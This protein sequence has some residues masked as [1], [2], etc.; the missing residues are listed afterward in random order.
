MVERSNIKDI[1]E[2]T[3]LQKGVLFHYVEDPTRHAYFEQMTLSLDGDVHPQ[4]LEQALQ[5]LIEK[6]DVLRTVFDH[7]SFKQPVQI[8]LKH[9]TTCIHVEDLTGF[10][11]EEQASAVDAYRV[12]DRSKGFTLSA[13]VL[14]RFALFKLK[15]DSW[16]LVW[17]HHHILLD[18]WCLE[19][20]LND[21][22]TLYQASLQGVRVESVSAAPPFSSYVKWL[23]AQPT[24][25]A[26]LYWDTYLRGYDGCTGIPIQQ[27]APSDPYQHGTYSFRLEERLTSG[28]IELARHNQVT[29]SS[30]FQAVWGVL[31]QKYNQTR[32]VVFG[33]VV[34]G[35]SAPVP[36]IERIVGLFIN[37]IP[38]RVSSEERGTI[39]ELMKSVQKHMLE[40]ERCSYLSL[41]DMTAS[42]LHH[43]QSINHVVTFENYPLD[44]DKLNEQLGQT[45]R[46]TA[47]EAFEQT[48][49]NIDLTVY[50]GASMA[51]VCTYNKSLY[52]EPF[53]HRIGG[54]LS[55]IIEQLL[56]RPDMPVSEIQLL[57]E[58]ERE[59]IA[60][61]T[62]KEV[63]EA[64]TALRTVPSLLEQQAQLQPDAVAIELGALSMT[65][66]AL[67]ER[68]SAAASMLRSRGL[69]GNDR[70]VVLM[71][72][73]MEAAVAM[74]AVIK[75]GA[76]YAA[77]DAASSEAVIEQALNAS[78]AA[79]LLV[80]A[81]WRQSHNLRFEGIVMTHAELF[82]SEEVVQAGTV[83]H[84]PDD[85]L[86]ISCMLPPSVKN[87]ASK[88]AL[89]PE[90][91]HAAF[92]LHMHCGERPTLCLP[93]DYVRT[94]TQRGSVGVSTI[95]LE[96]EWSRTLHMTAERNGVTLHM[97]L[98]TS[99]MI[100]LHKY[101]G[102]ETMNVAVLSCSQHGSSELQHDQRCRLLA[103]RYHCPEAAT[104]NAHLQYT[105][106]LVHAAFQHRDYPLDQLVRQLQESGS[107][108]SLPLFDTMFELRES[109][110]E[111]VDSCLTEQEAV[112]VKHLDLRLVAHQDEQNVTFSFHFAA[113]LFNKGTVDRMAAHYLELLKQLFTEPSM[114]LGQL[115][116]LSGEERERL[117]HDFNPIGL[118]PAP[119]VTFHQ[120]FEQQTE[121]TPHAVAVI[122]TE[123]QLTY[124]ELNTRANRLAHTLRSQGVL[125]NQLVGIWADRSTHL[126]TAVLAVWKAG[127]AYVPIDPEYPSERIR[128]M[129]EDSSAAVVLT[130]RHLLQGAEA[131]LQE[132]SGPE[133][134]LCLDD[135]EAY[136][137]ADTNPDPVNAPNDL[138]YVIYTSG[139]TGR[140]KG[141]MIEHVSLVNTAD[142]YRREYRLEQFPVRLLQLASFS[143]DVF[144]GDIARALYNGG[145]MVICPQEDRLDPRRLYSWITDQHIT[146]FESTPALVVP[147]LEYVYEQGWELSSMRLLITSSD[148]CRVNDYRT[149]QE[150]YGSKLRIMNSY[151]VTEAAIDSGFYD[152][153]LAK[154]PEAGNVPIGK[155]MLNAT[156]YIVDSTMNPVPVGVLGELCIGGIGVA[157][158]YWNRPELT[159]EKFV[160]SPF[161]PEQR[162]YRT[163]DLARWMEDGNVDFVGRIDH[164]AKIRGY[165]IETGEVEARLLQVPGV[166]EAVAV[167]RDNASGEK[168]LCAFMTASCQLNMLEVR[169][170]LSQ[171]LPSYMI[172]SY[173]LQLE[174][175]PITPNGKLDRKALPNPALADEACD[176]LLDDESPMRI[177]PVTHRAVHRLARHDDYRL[178]GPGSRCLSVFNG[179]P[180]WELELLLPLL[181]GATVVQVPSLN[182]GVEEQQSGL[183]R[184]LQQQSIHVLQTAPSLLKSLP[185]EPCP[186]LKLI[187][188]RGEAITRRL[189]QEWGTGRSLVH[190]YGSAETGWACMHTVYRGDALQPHAARPE[191]GVQVHVLNGQLQLQPVGLPGELYVG[192]EWIADASWTEAGSGRYVFIDNPF[193][194]GERLYRTGEYAKLLEAGTIL[195][196][197]RAKEYSPLQER[198]L[199][200]RMVEH[201]L[202]EHSLVRDAV[203]VCVGERRE[204]CA[205]IVVEQGKVQGKE[206]G[207]HQQLARFLQS[208]VPSEWLPSMFIDVPEIY[209][210]RDESADLKRL[211]LPSEPSGWQAPRNAT[212]QQLLSIWREVLGND[213][214]DC[215]EHFYT[216]GGH[217]LK[218]MLLLSRIQKKFQVN[219]SLKTMME[220]LTIRE[221]AEYVV[222]AKAEAYCAIQPADKQAYY[223]VSFV[224][225]RL[226]AVQQFEGVGTSYNVPTLIEVSGVLDTDAMMD[227]MR[228][229]VDRHE[230]LRTSFHY[231]N[232]ALLQKV[233]ERAELSIPLLFSSL[234][235]LPSML[236]SLVRPFALDQAPLLRCAIIRLEADHHYVLIDANHI[237]YD[238]LSG[239]M[240]VEELLRLYQG[241]SLPELELQYKDYAVWQ[242]QSIHTE[243]MQRQ[244]R[245]WLDRFGGELPVLELPADDPRPSVQSFEGS[246]VTFKLSDQTLAAARRYMKEQQVSLYV[247][248]FAVYSVLLAKYTGTE[249][250]VVGTT[251]TG[252]SHP[253]LE[254]LV[255][256]FAS[257]L[258]IRCDA[259]GHRTF[260]EHVR[261]IQS[262]IFDALEH[263]DYPLEQLIGKLKLQRDVSR[264][265]L[266]DTMLVMEPQA[267]RMAAPPGLHLTMH[268][269]EWTNAKLDLTWYVQECGDGVQL[270]VEYS[271]ALFRERTIQRMANHFIHVL[272]ACTA[273]PER[274]L[275]EVELMTAEEKAII[276]NQFNATAVTYPPFRSLPLIFQEQSSRSPDA[277]ALRYADQRLTYGELN[278]RVNSLAH[279]LRAKG[280]GRNIVV[281]VRMNRSLEMMMAILAILKAGGAY[282]PIAPQFPQ[283]RA[284]YMLGNSHA[285]LLLTEHSL[286]PLADGLQVECIYADELE[287]YNGESANPLPV[288]DAHD[289]AYVLYTSGS[290]GLPKGVMIEHGTVYNRLSWMVREYG[291]APCDVLLQ[292]T[293]IV[294]DVSVWELFMWFFVGASLSVLEPEAEKSPETMIQAIAKHGVTSIHFV[295][296]MLNTFLTYMELPGTIEQLGSLTRVFTSGEALL[297]SHVAR[298]QRTGHPARLYN[299]YGPTE[300][301][302]DVSYYNCPEQE[303][304]R[305]VPI[306]RPIHNVQLW[307]MNDR[308]QLQPIGVP[309]ELCISG[310]CLARGYM[311]RDELTQERFVQH[312][313]V[314]GGRLYRTGDLARWLPDGQIEYLGRID[315]QV[316]IRGY[317]IEL[318]EVAGC[319]MDSGIAR[320]AVVV[321]RSDSAGDLYLCAYY[322][323]HAGLDASELR[324]QLAAKLPEYMIPSCFVH[325]DRLP[326]THNGKLDRKALPEPERAAAGEYSAPADER[327]Q[328]LAEVWQ[329]VLKVEQVGV[330]DNFFELGGDSIKAIHVA[331]Q[332]NKRGLRVDMSDFFKRPTIRELAPCMRENVRRVSQAPIIGEGLLSP[333][334][335]WFFELE[336]ENHHH[337]NQAVLLH[338]KQGWEQAIVVEAMNAIIRHHD[339]LRTVFVPQPDGSFLPYFRPESEAQ[340]ELRVVWLE[341][342]E[343][344]QTCIERQGEQVHR[345][346]QLA[347]GPLTAGAL[348]KTEGEGDYLLLSIHHLVIDGVSWSILLDDFQAAYEQLQRQERVHLQDKT[349]SYME[350]CACLER[351]AV[352]D[353]LMQELR[354]WHSLAASTIDSL[355]T[356]EV[357]YGDTELHEDVTL[358]VDRVAAQQLRTSASMN[359]TDMQELL[360]AALV[361]TIAEW[362]GSSKVAIDLEGHGRE[363]LEDG[364]DLTRTIGWFTSLY[365]VVFPVQERSPA[366]V[367]RQV[368]EV[369]S[370]IPSRGIGYGILK[371]L[372][373][374]DMKDHGT[375]SLKPDILF[376]YLGEIGDAS[377]G[378]ATLIQQETGA[379]GSAYVTAPY[380]LELTGMLTKDGLLFKLGYSEHHLTRRTVERLSL[381]YGENLQRIAEHCMQQA[382]SKLTPS[383]FTAAKLT[384]EELDDI[385]EALQP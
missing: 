119:R 121:R 165:R 225:K 152:E 42:T 298:F 100:W 127:G 288:N 345:S 282:M 276:L 380:K 29:L 175:L 191:P 265:P 351:Y 179:H 93:T 301:T 229:I 192:G 363:V 281:G 153:P 315:N 357:P 178:L 326:L 273:A 160:A 295:P 53:I 303:E 88:Q 48:N 147:F 117:L 102:Q 216:V 86:C 311:N 252:R 69:G 249:D 287:L 308:M 49:Y 360:L 41:S 379:L 24:S 198:A 238:G 116:M 226:Y 251:S 124:M 201:A 37:T 52:T 162:L 82:A 63:D 83:V 23:Q 22:F 263:A 267:P 293:P 84:E 85:L 274:S 244:E 207:L 164:Q 338:R 292:K 46:V 32:D 348:F 76:V 266:F 135:D 112:T 316:K 246:T 187:V 159:S 354:Y 254:P 104:I 21:L 59:Q 79:F 358:L 13:D 322:T 213:K 333:I 11:E 302:I 253:D 8:V 64:R 214:L 129:L 286:P 167:V 220:H 30:A 36:H 300:A 324:R 352:S 113:G 283:D 261:Q 231:M 331:A 224:Q 92:W 190:V 120:L 186:D 109:G 130:L 47:I 133:S 350:W 111:S 323:A 382:S 275:N 155:P 290:T 306:G 19:I 215:N 228:Q 289:L 96:A 77:I 67:N 126:L 45:M 367:W 204:L 372:T 236:R 16:K 312:P 10:S 339:A 80:P 242:Q 235:E 296:S 148:S 264:H 172:P 343:G 257:T 40:A 255:G 54:H 103:L 189:I 193:R 205:F 332:L 81:S 174:R 219:L 14:I 317:R 1:Y 280:V 7:T 260:A 144:V 146:V 66:A 196:L 98:L 131:W 314:Q 328:W 34:S 101:T 161:H 384:V 166:R 336:L 141:V 217:S 95:Q 329:D 99:Y 33:T 259:A 142:A 203:V 123:E 366:H 230:S 349:T 156:F 27:M 245:Y 371:Y 15:D 355:P 62:S 136:D 222:R 197:G 353:Q 284:A 256:M 340:L 199:E 262:A 176:P 60:A 369:L 291:I 361:I 327:E 61:W 200:R 325:M 202:Q 108:N 234:E 370:A 320:E 241:E 218:L 114:H 2:L 149:M 362:T 279:I 154:L 163:G 304:P 139:T 188:I 78:G 334:Q 223:P 377:E 110:Q 20:I 337:W 376:N 305:I 138:A 50:P 210:A 5:G 177:V 140:P 180:V 209:A 297:P 221:Q 28:L 195:R 145:A 105:R 378:G 134:I 38:V 299:L 122:D 212:E 9:R 368:K 181:R 278:R 309:G 347:T 73:T 208:R 346:L 107:G 319:L 150:R 94:T 31:L 74:V 356:E 68:A 277:V 375:F 118:Q 169:D 272:E 35:R 344:A 270:V 335:R 232:G 381:R 321:A 269:A 44:L 97:L 132:W 374:A 26:Q 185:C 157:R 184:T 330:T 233:H 70:A 170:S 6:H 18:G 39:A 137:V 43:S 240:V 237:I 57:T 227:A 258:P 206:K 383:D 75:A 313:M 51:L 89:P 12:L 183:L 115:C 310:N 268:N 341:E 25:G 106:D 211:P 182:Y 168:V 128:Y 373:P 58:Q 247:L 3:P 171:L 55:R 385:L 248:L 65:Y 318:D 151:G 90:H 91:P 285:R 125:P 194:A 365:P 239:D 17:S 359:R 87:E 307:I 364:I 294:F 342:E 56:E 243:L 72:Q 173:L 143:F 158:G 4:A 250:F 71:E 271:T